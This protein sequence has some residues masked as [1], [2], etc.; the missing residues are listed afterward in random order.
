MS[1]SI[2]Q[3]E[4]ECAICG[5][6]YE[7]EC[8]HVFGGP[9]RKLSERHGLK[10]WL[11]RKHHTESPEGV[12]H[13]RELREELQDFAQR[14]AMKHYGWTMEEWREKFLRNYLKE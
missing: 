11:C 14:A 4:K 8:H 9:L 10:L 5:A 3:K 12:H 7:L 1:K 13:N 6:L 2:L